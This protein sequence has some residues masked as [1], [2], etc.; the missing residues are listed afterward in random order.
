M[1]LVRL[2][3]PT[4]LRSLANDAF[5]RNL[6]DSNLEKFS[7]CDS[8]DEVLF[9]LREEENE[10]LLEMAVPGFSK[11]MIQ[12]EV[13]DN[14]LTVKSVGETNEQ[15]VGSFALKS[16]EKRF[17]V[18]DKVNIESISARAEYGILY[19]TL[20]K[21]EEALKKPAQTIEIA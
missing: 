12:I 11:E 18:S 4:L 8:E 15:K 17:K 2:N 20:P 3:Q 6:F 16:F 19:I 14:V 7:A 5:A 21:T 10:V 9:N 13:E 1:T